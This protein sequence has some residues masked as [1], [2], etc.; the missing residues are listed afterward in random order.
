MGSVF[1]AAIVVL[2]AAPE[3]PGCIEMSSP[4]LMSGLMAGLV[5]MMAAPFLVIFGIGG[6]LFRARRRALAEADEHEGRG[7]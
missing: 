2:Q 7:G 4:N 3:C 1:E 6:G 5:L